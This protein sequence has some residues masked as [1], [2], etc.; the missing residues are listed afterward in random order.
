MLKSIAEVSPELLNFIDI[1]PVCHSNLCN[2][3]QT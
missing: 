1:L 3:E 2:Y